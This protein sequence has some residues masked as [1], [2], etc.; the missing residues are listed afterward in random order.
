MWSNR[1]IFISAIACACIV[2]CA[3]YFNNALVFIESY[4]LVP[5][6]NF[7]G[8]LWVTNAPNFLG[9]HFGRTTLGICM[10]LNEHRAE[11]GFSECLIMVKELQISTG[12]VLFVIGSV[13]MFLMLTF[14]ATAIFSA[15]SFYYQYQMHKD[16]LFLEKEKLQLQ[17]EKA[18]NTSERTDVQRL[19][20]QR[21]ANNKEAVKEAVLNIDTNN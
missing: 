10:T 12:F 18:K 15:I 2:F 17:S 20:E 11:K 7:L 19:T 9:G 3:V 5:L 1:N 21:K 16:R 6:F 14:S 8:E 13:L 4:L